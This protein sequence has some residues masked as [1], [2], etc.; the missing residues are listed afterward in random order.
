L[1][2][3]LKRYDR[4][5]IP[6]L[7]AGQLRLLIRQKYLVDAQGYNKIKGKPFGVSEIVEAIENF[8][9]S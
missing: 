5:L 7:N 4:V 3:I 1:G 8:V 6:E 2:E 9:K